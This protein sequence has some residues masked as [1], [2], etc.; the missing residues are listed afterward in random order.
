M[1]THL[2][3]GT[4]GL[5][6]AEVSHLGLDRSTLTPGI[7]HLGVGAFHR[8]HQAM[9]VD[10]CLSAGET[11]WGIVAASL[12][13]SQTRDALQP[14]DGL[15]TLAVRGGDDESLRVIGSILDLLVAPEN[16]P[17]L[18]ATMADPA[19]RIVSLT[20]TEKAYLRDA[21]GHVDLNDPDIRHDLSDPR[22]PHTIYGFIIEALARRRAAGHAPFTI[23]RC[24]NL[25]ANGRT[26]HR[27]LIEFAAQRSS[28]LAEFVAGEV[29]C[30]SSMVDRIVPATTEQDKSRISAAIGMTDAWPVVT[31][32][33]SDWVIEDR[34]PLGRPDWERFGVTM[35]ED[36][37]PFEIRKLRLLNGAHSAIAYL[38]QLLGLKTVSDAM[39]ATDTRQFIDGLWNELIPTLPQDKGL[40]PDLYTAKLAARFSNTA[41]KHLT[42]QIAN[43]GSQKLPQRI[44]AAACERLSG[45]ASADYL[46]FVVAAWIA[47]LQARSKEMAFSDP[48]DTQLIA[49]DF[50][51]PDQAKVVQ[52]I[53][54]ITGFAKGEQERSR[55]IQLVANHLKTIH[56]T[57]PKQAPGTDNQG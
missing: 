10:Q 32:P 52:T 45:R 22:N 3:R 37:A 17:A 14:Q 48:L 28:E 39:A 5:L 6:P 42:A 43:D 1:N 56:T 51:S 30:P 41:L 54:E 46:S 18:I 38:G 2:S 31:E 26:L 16:P 8:A 19:I 57:G 21:D 20:V 47:A 53:F 24:D 33:F 50:D 12:R 40:E 34:F 55:L 25:P 49:L 4:I 27:L 44:I 35:V 7:V 29:S 13:S 15:Y 9:Y 11:D 23:L 36:V